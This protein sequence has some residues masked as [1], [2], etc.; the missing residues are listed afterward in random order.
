MTPAQ[1]AT[2]SPPYAIGVTGNIA[3]GKSAVMARLAEHGAAVFDADAVYHALIAPGSALNRALRER[4]GE[5]IV[6]PDGAIDRA[7]LGRIV[8]ADPQ[9]LAAL[10]ALTHPAIERELVRRIA[11]SSAPIVAIDA[12]KLIEAGFDR[13]CDEVW[14]VVADRAQQIDRLM[15][16]NGLTA[17][18]ATRRVD[19][20][21][22]LAPKLARADIVID[23]RGDLAATRRQ[24][25]RAWR[26]A[27]IRAANRSAAAPAAVDG[28]SG[29]GGQAS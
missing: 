8:F 13:A 25:D 28:A 17:E 22:P 15:R 6:R 24:V 19:A 11:A 29:A 7:A 27:K 1:Q 18:A 12:V 14:V 9:A 26:S 3:V 20:Q 21:P 23:N 2:P 4:F 16:R 5:S 10:D